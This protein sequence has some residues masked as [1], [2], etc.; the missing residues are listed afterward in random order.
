MNPIK[1]IRDKFGIKLKYPDRTCKECSKYPCF[2]GMTKC[3]SDFAK[4]GCFLWSNKNK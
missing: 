4:Y 3:L 2:V 1:A